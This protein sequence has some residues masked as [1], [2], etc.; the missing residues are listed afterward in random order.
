MEED[1][2]IKKSYFIRD[3]CI[4]IAVGL[5]IGIILLSLFRVSRVEGISME[6]TLENGEQV[7]LDLTYQKRN[8]LKYNDIVVF[9]KKLVSDDYYVKRV[10]AVEGD[11]VEIVNNELGISELYING[12]NINEKYIKEDMIT[13]E[14]TVVVPSGEIFVMGDNR[15]RSMDSRES[16][17]G[18]VSVEDE[19]YGKVI[20]NFNNF[21]S[22]R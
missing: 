10:I 17:I 22:V 9:D 13:D 7:L 20:F 6:P 2:K 14:L 12:Q 21:E 4:S 1:E 5:I 16:F 8:D 11:K 15:N 3:C 19:V 18:L